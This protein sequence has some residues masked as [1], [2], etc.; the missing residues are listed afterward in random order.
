MKQRVL[1]FLWC[2]ALGA[3]GAELRLARLFT[4]HLVLQRDKPIAV[5][6]FGTAGESVSVGFEGEEATKTTVDADGFWIAQLPARGASAKP[7][8]LTVRSDQT[9]LE[10]RDILIGD[11][12]FCTG[13]SN[14]DFPVCR[15]NDAAREM[16]AANHATIRLLR[17]D[18]ISAVDPQADIPGGTGWRV[19][20]P[21]SVRNFSAV[22]YYF[23]R[24]IQTKVDVPIGL[25][26]SAWP[27]PPIWH[28]MP[29]PEWGQNEGMRKQSNQSLAAAKVSHA[30]WHEKVSACLALEQDAT[31]LGRLAVADLEGEAGGQVQLPGEYFKRELKG[32]GGWIRFTRQVTLPEAWEGKP[33]V[34]S[35]WLRQA[36]RTYV[37]GQL[38]GQGESLEQSIWDKRDHTRKYSVPADA[39]RPGVNTLSI[40]VG[41]IDRMW[42]RGG[43][44]QNPFTLSLAEDPGQSLKL[45]GAWT[46]AKIIELPSPE[47]TYGNAY[48]SMIH[49]FFRYPIKG[50]LFYQGEANTRD[51]LPYL[52]LQ[53]QMVRDWRQQ[54]GYEF[55]FYFVQLAAH[56]N[57][58]YPEGWPILREAQ[59]LTLDAFPQ[60]G[61][62]TAIDIGAAHDIHPQNKQDVGRR[63]ALQALKSGYG[64]EDT[65]ADGPLLESVELKGGT[66][67]V[68][69]RRTGSPL[70]IRGEVL[71]GFEV[72]ANKDGFHPAKARIVGP[73]TVEVTA[74]DVVAPIAF[75]RYL[76]QDNPVVTL[77][78]AAGLPASSFTTVP[79]FDGQPNPPEE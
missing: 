47:R 11:V 5:Y 27:G 4:D 45:A 65:V 44:I 59:R 33:L 14:M 3:L 32:F 20:S 53:C 8:A 36:D 17:V 40:L 62:A 69:F 15:A 55:P 74:P 49:P 66:A 28:F 64:F 67:L 52:K 22:A 10:L 21:Q 42:W 61:M 38:V 60:V 50:A 72:A 9:Q 26:D 35:M 77:G 25:I 12:W 51:P 31:A 24:E 56:V 76:W 39:L 19:C 78:N 54:W 7:L 46:Y 13:Q 71:A 6:G 23:A 29:R 58:K 63:L 70:V 37:N 30:A 34:F 16:A 1:I 43:N 75:V 48:Y 79:L 18:R 57:K 2:C 73:D 68:R 41:D